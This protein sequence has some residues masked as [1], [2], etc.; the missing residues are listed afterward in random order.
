MSMCD[1]SMLPECEVHFAEGTRRMGEIMK[2]LDSMDDHIRNGMTSKITRN[3]AVLSV[4]WPLVV[5]MLT[6]LVGVAWK[7]IGR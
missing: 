6:G 7:V 3:G 4:L 1:R 5:I 2:K